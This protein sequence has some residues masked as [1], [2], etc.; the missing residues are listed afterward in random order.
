MKWYN[1]A[2]Y[3]VKLGL[4][5]LRWFDAAKADGVITLDEMTKGVTE[6]LEVAGLADDVRI[7]VGKRKTKT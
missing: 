2:M 4:A 7:E 6:L 3:V 1:R 5:A